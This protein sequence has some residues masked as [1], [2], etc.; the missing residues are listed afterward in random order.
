VINCVHPSPLAGV[1]FKTIK[2]FSECNA[3]L[4]EKGKEEIDWNV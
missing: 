1:A 2:C 3:Y 4:K